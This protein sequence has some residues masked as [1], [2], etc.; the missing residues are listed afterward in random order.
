MFIKAKLAL[1]NRLFG[2]TSAVLRCAAQLGRYVCQEALFL[3]TC[4]RGLMDTHDMIG[5]IKYKKYENMRQKPHLY[6]S[7]YSV[8]RVYRLKK[9]FKSPI[10]WNMI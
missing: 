5:G 4:L 6:A 7:V 8:F 2:H 9:V 3:L 10:I 1:A